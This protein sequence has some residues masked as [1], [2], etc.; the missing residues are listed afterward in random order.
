MKKY[1]LLLLLVSTSFM[2]FADGNDNSPGI[3]LFLLGRELDGMQEVVLKEER[4]ARE[5]REAQERI[6]PHLTDM[7]ATPKEVISAIAPKVA[8]DFSLRYHC[9]KLNTLGYCLKLRATKDVDVDN[10]PGYKAMCSD[11]CYDDIRHRYPDVV[12]SCMQNFLENR[13]VR[14]RA[15]VISKTLKEFEELAGSLKK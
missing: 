1:T 9:N 11:V 14:E 5:L 4:E 10:D 12:V 2:S 6:A 8:R 3:I 7:P 13:G 15:E